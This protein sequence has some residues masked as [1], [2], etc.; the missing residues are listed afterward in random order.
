M[1]IDEKWVRSHLPKRDNQTNKSSF[2]KLFAII[3]SPMY[4]GAA[5]LTLEAALR[6]GAGYTYVSSAPEVCD[7]LLQSFPEAIYRPIRGYGEC[8]IPSDTSAVLLGCGCGTSLELAQL[9]ERTLSSSVPTVIIDAD[10]IN[11]IAKFCPDPQK[12]LTRVDKNVIITPHP[13]EMARLLGTSVDSV[14][15]QRERIAA[16][17]A[18]KTGVTVI[19]KGYHTVVATPGKYMI[20][21]SGSSALAKAGSGDCLAGLLAS[22]AA[23]ALADAFT[24]SAI[25]AYVHGRAGD[26]LESE[27]SAYGVTPSDLPRKMAQ[28]LASLS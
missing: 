26:E 7:S 2:G 6:G 17:F 27:L 15:M 28:V 25:A 18:N 12:V 19:L 9:A 5:H 22:L 23:T 11:S 24:C 20:N 16:D 4:R 1:Y 8:E 13:L 10:G 14:Q 21:T 3:G